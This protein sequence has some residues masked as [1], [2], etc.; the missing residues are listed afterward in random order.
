MPTVVTTNSSHFRTYIYRCFKEEFSLLSRLHWFFAYSSKLAASELSNVALTSDSIFIK[1]VLPISD[2]DNEKLHI[3]VP[4]FIASSTEY[5]AHLRMLLL[6]KGVASLEEF[7][8]RYI[9]YFVIHLGYVGPRYNKINELGEA[10]AKPAM[11]SN[12]FSCLKYV[13]KLTGCAFGTNLTKVKEAYQIRCAAAHNGGIID[14]ETA[15]KLPQFSGQIG[16]RIELEW[17]ALHG[18][19]K[20][21]H[22]VALKIEE[23]L[24]AN[25]VRAVEVNWLLQD[26]F[27]A[28]GALTAR[29]A[30]KLLKQEYHYQF[31]PSSTLIS[32]KFGCTN[33]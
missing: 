33:G 7:T 27:D 1:D 32:Q 14:H 26:L 22:A 29:Q 2:F 6:V 30:R 15:K 18:Y 28:N 9:Q 20:S 3:S 4:D 11:A 12:L 23:S 5:I 21:I 19:L 8:H 25:E 31:V 16:K 10:L 13:E 24:N 17:N